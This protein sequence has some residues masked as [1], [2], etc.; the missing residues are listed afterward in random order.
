M[1]DERPLQKVR[2]IDVIRLLGD[3]ENPHNRMKKNRLYRFVIC[4]EKKK[5][6]QY[7]GVLGY[8]G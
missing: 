6:R 7:L 8:I 5:Q 1:R 3:K 4:V 2:R